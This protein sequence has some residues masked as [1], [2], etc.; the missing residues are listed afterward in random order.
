MMDLILSSLKWTKILVYID[1]IIVFSRTFDDHVRDII[2]VLDALNVTDLRVKLSKCV[3]CQKS[4]QFL[5][6]VISWEEVTTASH[7]CKAILNYP[8]PGTKDDICKFLGLANFYNRFIYGYT[9]ITKP[10]CDASIS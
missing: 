5:G 2:E 3:W 7:I 8:M 9:H 10:L 1:D 4:V 6:H